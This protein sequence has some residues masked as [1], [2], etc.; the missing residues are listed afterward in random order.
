MDQ[1]HCTGEGLQYLPAPRYV[2]SR[3]QL[4]NVSGQIILQSAHNDAEKADQ[5]AQRLQRDQ[6]HNQGDKLNNSYFNDRVRS[7]DD[8]KNMG[9]SIP[10]YSPI[11]TV[12]DAVPQH[13]AVGT[14]ASVPTSTPRTEGGSCLHT[15]DPTHNRGKAK[16]IDYFA[17]IADPLKSLKF[18]HGS[19]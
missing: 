12:G 5:E 6:N 1:V 14:A 11:A 3:G 7:I 19:Y 10:D 4:E 16:V 17:A 13:P 18:S 2:P 9:F 8:L 15:T